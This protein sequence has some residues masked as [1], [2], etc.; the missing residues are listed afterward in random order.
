[1]IYSIDPASLMRIWTPR[2]AKDNDLGAETEEAAEV[3]LGANEMEVETEISPLRL[4]EGLL[5]IETIRML[6]IIL[7]FALIL[8]G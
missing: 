8:R 7:L 5:I 1:M 4:G 6:W 2:P 3:R